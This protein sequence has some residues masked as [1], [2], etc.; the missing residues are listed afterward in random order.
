MGFLDNFKAAMK[1]G[2]D[3]ANANIER[4]RAEK[5]AAQG[6]RPAQ[7]RPQSAQARPHSAQARPQSRLPEGV[8]MATLNDMEPLPLG[9]NSQGINVAVKIS[10][11]ILAKPMGVC[12]LDANAQREEVKKIV[13]ATLQ[14]ELAPQ[15][16]SMG[17]IKFLMVTANRMNPVVIENLKASGFEAAFK[18]PLVIRPL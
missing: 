9:I 17:D 5:A 15:V 1:A 16:N 3:A 7:A 2:A 10:G 12:P 11:T 8:I 4:Q 13:R 6:A 14:R 18:I